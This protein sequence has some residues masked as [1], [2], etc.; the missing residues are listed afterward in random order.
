MG[1]AMCANA[2]RWDGRLDFLGRTNWVYL[3]EITET[4]TGLGSLFL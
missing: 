2:D 3:Q 4:F 1:D